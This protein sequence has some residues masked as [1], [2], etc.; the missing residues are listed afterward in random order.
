[1]VNVNPLYTARELEHQLSDSGAEILV[2]VENFAHTVQ[3]VVARTKLR[4]VVVTTIGELLGFKGIAV[5]IV[6]RHLKKMVPK[7]SLPDSIKLSDALADGR[8]RTLE[9]VGLGHEDVA[10]LQYTGGTTGVAKGAVLLHRNIVANLLQARA[11][12][13]PF[14]GDK[15]EVIITPLPLYHIFS[16]TANCLTFM[17]LG[18]ENILIPNPRDIPGFVKEMAALQIHGVH[19][20]QHAV[21]RARQQ[22][23]VRQARLRVA[24]DDARR[25]N[26]GAGSRRR[27]MEA[28]HG[29]HAG[30][31]V[32]AHR[33]LAR[34]AHQSSRHPCVQ[35]HDRAADSLDRRRA[36]RRCRQGRPAR[37]ARRDLRPRAR[38]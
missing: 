36:A 32:R 21:Q 2:V 14:L 11:W 27:Q 16:L 29:L 18:G 3:E 8:R 22:P 20:R 35:R 33:D 4:R 1:M 34:G 23:G 13:R 19:R 24:A 38:R 25:G 7:W 5:D 12:I 26:G 9:R 10:F 15:R 37:S 28:R 6:I 31:G 17:T 30:R